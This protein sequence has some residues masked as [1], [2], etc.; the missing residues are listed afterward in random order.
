MRWGGTGRSSRGGA[1]DDVAAAADVLRAGGVVLLPT[2]TLYGVAVATDVP[3]ATERL[4]SLK[5]RD[6][7]VPIAVL[8]ADAVQAWTLV[9]PP[10]PEVA[11]GLAAR[12][13]PGALTLVLRREPSWTVDL[14]GDATTVGLR[15]PDHEL[16]R[17]LCRSVGPLAT[18][19]ANRHGHP[20]PPTAQDAAAELG[21][22]DLVVDGGRLQGMAS[23]VVDCTVEPVRVLREGAIPRDALVE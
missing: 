13:W 10:V 23:T 9:A 6:R 14:G 17:A 19:S 2:D 15:C 7:D 22:V 8:V 11:A 21:A 4:F 20:T 3:G 1:V 5:G 12:F 16:V 18:T